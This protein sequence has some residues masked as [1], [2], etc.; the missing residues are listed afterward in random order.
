MSD[1]IPPQVASNDA[2]HDDDQLPFTPIWSC[3]HCGLEIDLGSDD[4]AS[5]PPPSVIKQQEGQCDGKNCRLSVQW[6]VSTG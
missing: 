3:E 6:E 2:E 4:P 1:E 5:L